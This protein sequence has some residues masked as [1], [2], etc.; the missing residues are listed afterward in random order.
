[1]KL[2]EK[3]RR[4]LKKTFYII[5]FYSLLLLIINTIGIVEIPSNILKNMLVY[6]IISLMIL[7]IIVEFIFSK[8]VPESFVNYGFSEKMSPQLRVEVEKQLIKDLENYDISLEECRFDW[9]G[10][11]I[12]GFEV[13]FMDGRLDNFSGIIIRDD[14]KNV[15]VEG[16]MDFIFSEDEKILIV[17]WDNL[18]YMGKELKKNFGIPEYV[19]EKL[20]ENLKL[21]CATKGSHWENDP[22]VKKFINERIKSGEIDWKT[23][24]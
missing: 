23:T 13:E 5:F 18:V 20:S 14:K 1:M 8:K 9:S 10:S 19:W 24:K 22:K 2:T 6:S 11:V 21:I 3:I 17:Y 4:N 15:L 12:E 7:L 16:W